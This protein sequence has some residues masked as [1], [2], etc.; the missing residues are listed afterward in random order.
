VIPYGLVS[1]VPRVVEAPRAKGIENNDEAIIKTESHVEIFFLLLKF[2]RPKF[3]PLK[4]LDG[5]REY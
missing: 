4:A 1:V 3:S 5:I 2:L